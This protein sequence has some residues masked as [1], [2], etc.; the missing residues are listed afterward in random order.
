MNRKI[1][2]GSIIALCILVGV[3]FTSAVG[4][5]SI[6]SDVKASPLFNIRSSRAIDEES[7]DFTTDYV[8]NGHTINLII[9]DKDDEKEKMRNTIGIIQELDDDSYNKFVD[10]VVNKILTNND[11]KDV[12]IDDLI[13]AFKEIRNNEELIL[14]DNANVN[15]MY[16][17]RYDFVPT[18][19]WFPGCVPIAIILIPFY[20]LL[21][22]L[23]LIFSTAT[24]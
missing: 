10:Y 7:G 8:G 11:F 6:A 19:C 4:Y 23:G 5:R 1:L 13:L 24:C 14:L 3:S 18:I 9:P 17:L 22:I 15:G 20:I 21:Y 12:K 2:F 16:T